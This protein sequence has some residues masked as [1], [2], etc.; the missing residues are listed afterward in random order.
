MSPIIV[1][2]NGYTLA[3]Y[4][5]SVQGKGY[6][7]LSTPVIDRAINEGRYRI[8]R[9]HRWSWVESTASPFV[10]DAGEA[11]VDLTSIPDLLYLDA[12][13]LEGGT[14][15]YDLDYVAPQNFRS[16][17]TD[18]SSTGI[19]RRWTVAGGAIRL[20]PVPA[21]AYALTVDFSTM[22]PDLLDESDTDVVPRVYADLVA[23]AACLAL[24]F[25]QREAW[26]MDYADRQYRAAL[27]SAVHQDRLAQR[28]TSEQVRPYWSDRA[29]YGG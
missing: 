24:G 3:E 6:D 21:S 13:R 15:V 28:Q 9:D 8:L 25:R 1:P 11:I 20:D 29:G 27:R 26:A 18:Y 7:S 16:D 22:P 2:G 5:S 14:E 4:R 23:W 17:E 19:P 10:A 12:V